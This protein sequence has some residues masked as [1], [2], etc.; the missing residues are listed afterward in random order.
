MIKIIYKESLRKQRREKELRLINMK[1][2]PDEFDTPAN[3]WIF[4]DKV[5]IIVWSEQPIATVIR[6]KEV[7]EA[8]KINFSLLWKLARA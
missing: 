7:A 5:V 6:S 8:Y 1:Y 3:T 2:L 4:G